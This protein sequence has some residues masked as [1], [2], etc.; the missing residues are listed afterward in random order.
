MGAN[1]SIY[2]L[3]V[4]VRANNL[5][6]RYGLDTISLGA[7][8]AAFFELYGA[9]ENCSGRLSREEKKLFDDTGNFTAEFGKPGFGK[10]E[11]L[12]PLIRLIGES[13]GIGR[14][15]GMGSYRFCDRYGR[16]EL[17]MSVKKLEMPAYDPRTSYSQARC[18]EM[19]NRGGGHLEGGYTSPHAYCAGYGEWPGQRVEGTA[20]ISRNAALKNT[21]V[22]IIG[23]C[24]YGTFTLGLDEY[25]SMVSAVTG[26]NY[27]G[28]SLKRFALRTLT[29]ERMFNLRCGLDASHDW[30]PDR[31]YEEPVA[32]REGTVVCDRAAFEK[33]HRE[34]YS[35]M[36]WDENGVPLP[37]TLAELGLAEMVG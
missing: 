8:L 35:A 9:L 36:G 1:L 20:L 11:L 13:R 37:E 34:F 4:I 30:L 19:N 24:A 3:P 28:G 29:L 17:S 18:Y 7:T 31:F 33:M 12:L 21:A 25:A 23:A 10:P 22:D 27:T 32:T 15:L 14:L 2:D 5:A 6:N 26:K 16:P